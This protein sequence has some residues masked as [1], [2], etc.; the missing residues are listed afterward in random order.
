MNV[1][2]LSLLAMAI[3]V[4]A[5]VGTLAVAEQS[6]A[7]PDEDETH[8]QEA[9][10]LPST[11]SSDRTYQV[12]EKQF[13]GYKYT[14]T[15]SIAE[16]GTSGDFSDI[17]DESWSEL[18]STSNSSAGIPGTF[19]PG[20]NALVAGFNVSMTQ[21]AVGKY[22]MTVT[23]TN[24]ALS[25]A[26]LV[27]RC[28]MEITVDGN[29]ITLS[30][31]YYTFSVVISEQATMSFAKLQLEVGELYGAEIEET[32][33]MIS[34]VGSY[35]WYAVGL[36]E[37]IS[38]SDSGYISGVPLEETSADATV[39][40]VATN[41]DTGATYTGD[42]TVSVDPADGTLTSYGF[43]VSVNGDERKGPNYYA[44]QGESV[45]LKTYNGTDSEK[46]L[47]DAKSVTVVGTDGIVSTIDNGEDVGEYAIPTN[48]TGAYRVVMTFGSDDSAESA[49]FYLFVSPSL[50]DISAGITIT[51]N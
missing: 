46:T 23:S 38:M 42:L 47:A 7:E 51:G 34:K 17:T 45:T 8:E 13:E 9:L 14:M 20:S 16:R 3:V 31:V 25:G 5:S 10:V 41:K 6:Q 28:D 43:A 21:G 37:G 50:N 11:G 35:H 1:R 49:E 44:V 22:T 18:G 30:E 4:L 40:I 27:L 32:T 12:N 39:K 24:A 48:G 26:D 15:W 29:E 33:G 2:I 36:P 19:T